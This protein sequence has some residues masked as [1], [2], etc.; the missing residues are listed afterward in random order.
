MTEGPQPYPLRPRIDDQRLA[1][2]VGF[3]GNRLTARVRSLP[4]FLII[5]AMK[6]GTSSLFHYLQR[7]PMIEPPIR[8]EIHFFTVGYHKGTSWYRAHFPL[9]GALSGSRITG[10][11]CPDYMFCPGAEHRIYRLLPDVRLIILLRDPVER[12][13]S[14]YFHERRMGREY[15][16]I[17]EALEVEE[18]RLAGADLEDPQG[19]ETYLHASYKRRGWYA[20]HI[21]RYFTLF[22]RDRILILGSGDLFR[23]SQRTTA[24]AIRF[25]GL[26]AVSA[27]ED[28]P[29]KNVG[30][31]EKVPAEVYRHLEEYFEP[32]ELRLRELLGRSIVW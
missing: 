8:K 17:M 11:G 1:R 27:A 3:L 28:Y 7:H 9:R 12:A 24:E 23:D 5:G 25:L 10:E 22:P 18:E 2:P 29:P 13:I 15:L 19:L 6:S 32:H 16:P 31:R 21:A 20:S 14:H 30:D 26:P 4:D